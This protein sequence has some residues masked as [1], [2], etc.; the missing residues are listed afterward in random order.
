MLYSLP[1]EHNM[2]TS[3]LD[4]GS[5]LCYEHKMPH[6]YLIFWLLPHAANFMVV[7]LK[8]ALF[9]WLTWKWWGGGLNILLWKRKI[10]I[11]ALQGACKKQNIPKR[12]LH[13]R[14][15]QGR[16][17]KVSTPWSLRAFK[18]STLQWGTPC[19]ISWVL[20]FALAGALTRPSRESSEPY[21]KL[22][23]EKKRKDV[24]WRACYT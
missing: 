9:Q 2:N 8:A 18:L 1:H 17:V 11:Q 14:C 12:L 20:P 3:W 6:P 23:R 21:W 19:S 15:L 16:N 4:W 5:W 10:K 24:L 22:R 7:P 13:A